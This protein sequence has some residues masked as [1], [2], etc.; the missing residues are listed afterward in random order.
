MSNSFY[1][2]AYGK[3]KNV[4]MFHESLELPMSEVKSLKVGWHWHSSYNKCSSLFPEDELENFLSENRELVKK[5]K[6]HRGLVDKLIATIV[7]EWNMNEKPQGYSIS[8]HLIQLLAEIN[9]SLEVDVFIVKDYESIR[10][11][12]EV[13]L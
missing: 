6:K 9:A 3:E 10:P 12:T 13:A 4:Y 2:G 11:P 1:L 5:I 8:P 7:Y